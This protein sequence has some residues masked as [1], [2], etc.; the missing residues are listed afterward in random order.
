MVHH[1]P[2][3][4][5]PAAP[6]LAAMLLILGA[7]LAA[8][9]Q[10]VGGDRTSYDLV[11]RYTVAAELDWH[12][13]TLALDTTIELDNTSGGPVS[14]LE[15][16]TLAVALGSIEL[17]S[18]AVDGRPVSVTMGEQTIRVPLVPALAAGATSTVEVS[19][20]ASLRRSTRGLGW[21]FTESKGIVNLYRFIPWLSREL[22]LRS[23]AEGD[24][25]VTPVSPSVRVTLTSDRP[26]TYA[27]SGRRVAADGLS[28]TFVAHDVRDFNLT[29]SP[30][31]RVRTG[32][33]RDGDTIIRVYWVRG[34]PGVL[35]RAARRAL[36]A[37]E[38]WV[39]PYPYPTLD[40]AQSAGGYA[41]ESPALVWIPQGRTHDIAS[42][43][44]HEVAH[45]WF[46]AVVGNDQTTD[47]WADEA[48]SEFLTLTLTGG[49]RH[50]DC[51]RT[52]L[53]LSL[54][55]Y[56]PDCYFEVIY[57]Q[58]SNFLERLRRDMGDRAF[59]DALWTYY[60]ENRLTVSTDRRLLEAL[61]HEAGDWVLAR[62]HA[63]FPSLY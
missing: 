9:V 24:P 4:R 58:G 12:H 11:A 43:V 60:H 62:F 56:D 33:S 1:L 40:V 54:Y 37:F 18:V 28:Q 32:R 35:L 49:F 21:L 14:R 5:W 38:R 42:F 46:Y 27:T 48:L 19:Y 44:A 52:R 31:Y 6:V 63:R 16:N 22:S 3:R 47:P 34:D 29:A 57:V 53:D 59:W 41:M 36:D 50:S 8:P 45:Q 23:G 7:G 51:A 26:L 55:A 10:A 13:A 25:F 61:R 15:L 17:G 30:D 20:Q 2:A 39:G